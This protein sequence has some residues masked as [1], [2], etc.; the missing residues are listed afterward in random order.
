MQLVSLCAFGLAGLLAFAFGVRYLTT[1]EFMPYHATVLGKQWSELEPRLQA[2]I[3]GMLKVAGSGLL[4]CGCALLWLLLPLSRGEPW[5]AW[6]AVTF[7]L[8]ATG[9]I[10]YVVLWLRRISPGAKTPVVPTLAAMALVIIGA[11]AFVVS[12][13]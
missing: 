1:R 6:A 5:A 13:G 10:L 11:L 4:G 2:I 8:V 12:R 3:L 9:P 7:F